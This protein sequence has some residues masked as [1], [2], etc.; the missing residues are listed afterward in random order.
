MASLRQSSFPMLDACK[1]DCHLGQI[2][3]FCN[4]MLKL[5]SVIFSFIS[6]LT[7]ESL[8]ARVISK[9]PLSPSK[10]GTIT[11][12]GCTFVRFSCLGRMVFKD[13]YWLPKFLSESDITCVKTGQAWTR[14]STRPAA[15]I[16]RPATRKVGKIWM[17]VCV[18]KFPVSS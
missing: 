2:C 3:Q 16:P 6:Q 15:T 13:G 11:I 14:L 8:D 5:S 10:A 18:N 7:V 4:L 17:C 1:Q 12:I 9:L